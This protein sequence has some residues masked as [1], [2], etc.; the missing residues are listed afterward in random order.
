VPK[1]ESG[2]KQTVKLIGLLMAAKEKM[3]IWSTPRASIL[4]SPSM[5]SR[6]LPSSF[7]RVQEELADAEP[8]GGSHG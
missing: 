2:P 7:L 8:V 5:G 3:G 4:A 6:T 1:A